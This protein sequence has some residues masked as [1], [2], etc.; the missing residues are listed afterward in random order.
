MNCNGKKKGS[1]SEFGLCRAAHCVVEAQCRRG[2]RQLSNQDRGFGHMRHA[3]GHA[4]LRG[5]PG[6]CS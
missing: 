5:P 1:Q 3:R 6:S 4:E 2:L